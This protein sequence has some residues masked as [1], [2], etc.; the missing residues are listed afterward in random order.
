MAFDGPG[1]F[2]GDPAF[3]FQHEIEGARP[4]DVEAAIEDAL[5]V[6]IEREYAE[7]DEGVWAWAA[8]ELMARS[9]GR[10]SAT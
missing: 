8:A 1:P 10:P 3:G 7:I 4:L 5:C 9:L 6:V 2:D